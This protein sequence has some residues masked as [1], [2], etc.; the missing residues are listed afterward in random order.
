MGTTLIGWAA[1]V[2]LICTLAK[3]VWKLWRERSVE[4]VSKWLFAGQITASV[5][6]ITYSVLLH[7]V[8]FV[9]TNALILVDAILGAVIVAR[10]RRRKARA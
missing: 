9:V 4:G 7:S 5:L 3:Q 10:N 1:S 6:F 8:V 2:V